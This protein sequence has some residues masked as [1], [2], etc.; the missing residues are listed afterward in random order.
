V[1]PRPSN[2]DPRL[3]DELRAERERQ[4]RSQESLAHDAGLTTN[5]LSRIEL[6]QAD[7][8]F[9]T[10][11]RIAKALGLTRAELMRRVDE[12]R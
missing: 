2:P 8:S 5:A 11:T 1:A 3:G 7:P 9:S 10:V 12:K 6:G 4:G